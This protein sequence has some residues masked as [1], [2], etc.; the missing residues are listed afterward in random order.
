MTRIGN[1]RKH[2]ERIYYP[3]N[4]V[5]HSIRPEWHILFRFLLMGIA[6]VC[7]TTKSPFDYLL[8]PIKFPI[9]VKVR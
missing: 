7:T 4:R 6:G 5:N 8:N 9:S 1:E 2:S 3:K